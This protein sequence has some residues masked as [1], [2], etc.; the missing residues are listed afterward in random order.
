VNVI[1][2]PKPGK[3]DYT[4]RRAFRPISLMSVLFKTLERFVLWHIEETSQ[5]RHP[6]QGSQYCFCKDKSTD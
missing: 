6:M 1:F 3:N 5:N 2:I 4:D